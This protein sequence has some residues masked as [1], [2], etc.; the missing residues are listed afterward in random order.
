MHIPIKVNVEQLVNSISRKWFG[1]LRWLGLVRKDTGYRLEWVV[2][3]KYSDRDLFRINVT[4]VSEYII[5]E[6]DAET[7]SEKIEAMSYS[8]KLIGEILKRFKNDLTEN[9]NV[10]RM[11][12]A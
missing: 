11:T 2:R 5:V 12:K 10:G 3:N 4:I 9:P 7:K 1:N 6:S 8:N